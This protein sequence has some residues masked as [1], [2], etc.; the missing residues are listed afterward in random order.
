[1]HFIPM[2]EANASW[3]GYEVRTNPDGTTYGVPTGAP[4]GSHESAVD[5][6]SDTGLQSRGTVPG[7]CGTS[8]VRFNSKTAVYTAY[9]IS[10]SHGSPISHNWSVT[11]SSSID[12]VVH[13]MSGL[14]P[15][16]NQTWSVVKPVVGKAL[17]GKTLTAMASG[18]VLTT[19]GCCAS[20]DPTDVI[21]F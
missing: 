14:A 2:T 18:T 16:G 6:Q 20:G 12:L 21:T 5:V 3:A 7:N 11:Y 13:D 1:M 17:Q 10:P 4:A 19:A 15:L 8:T 9:T